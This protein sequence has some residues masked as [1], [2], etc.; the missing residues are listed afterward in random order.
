MPAGPV[1][2]YFPVRNEGQPGVEDVIRSGC[3]RSDSQPAWM[4]EAQDV[5]Q[6]DPQSPSDL[7]AG[8]A[9][10]LQ[11]LRLGF[12]VAVG[13]CGEATRGR[14]QTPTRS[15]AHTGSAPVLHPSVV[16]RLQDRH[17][18]L[19]TAVG[20]I[21]GVALQ[22]RGLPPRQAPRDPLLHRPVE[23]NTSGT[24]GLAGATSPD[25][26]GLS[27][28]SLHGHRNPSLEADSPGCIRRRWAPAL[29]CWPAR[30]AGPPALLAGAAV[31]A[32]VGLG[33]GGLMSHGEKAEIKADVEHTMPLNSSGI[34]AM[35]EE[36]WV[37]DVEKALSNASNVTA[38]RRVQG[39]S[40]QDRG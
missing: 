7:L 26:S 40:G 15:S 28:R 3:A 18:V 33:V 8:V 36:Q 32:G 4:V 9:S 21:P 39:E 27:T 10:F 19:P 23:V 1:S 14:T 34:V 11:Y 29:R 2:E 37:T 31:G 13:E 20:R 35:F 6:L 25:S 22:R 24:L 30:P 16:L 17:R 5:G 38:G 12:G